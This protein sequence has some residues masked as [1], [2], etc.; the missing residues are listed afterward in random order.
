M[1]GAL[2]ETRAILEWVANELGPDTYV[3][4]MDQCRPAGKVGRAA[5]PEINRRIHAEE[6][7]QAVL[8]ARDLGLQRKPVVAPGVVSSTRYA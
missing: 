5:Y 8:I 4:L 6:F 1:P 3:N 7:A 2:E